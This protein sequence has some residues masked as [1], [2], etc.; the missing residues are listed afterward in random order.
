MAAPGRRR[1]KMIALLQRVSEASVHVKE[2]GHSRPVGAIGPGLL[3]LLG[4]E[5]GDGEREC[6][7]LLERLLAYRVFPD[8]EGRMNLNLDQVGGGL[9][10]VPQFTLVADT[11]RGNR[12]G[13][14]GAAE[15]ALG[16]R[17]FERMCAA[18]GDRPGGCEAGEFGANMAVQLVND[19]PVTFWLRVPP[20]EET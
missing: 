10:I 1:K 2:A 15:P 20:N 18:A 5:R 17:L 11:R 6:D 9:L 13:F 4:V 3:V 8:A 12:P 16:R 7:R 14:S 19:G